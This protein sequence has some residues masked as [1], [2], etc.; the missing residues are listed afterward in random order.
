MIKEQDADNMMTINKTRCIAV[1]LVIVL[2]T[3][4]AGCTKRDS[5][6]E[7]SDGI[8]HKEQVTKAY[9]KYFGLPKVVYPNT[10]YYVVFY[11]YADH[12]PF[13]AGKVKPLAKHTNIGK[14]DLPR[15]AVSKLLQSPP[16]NDPLLTRL[17][18]PATKVIGVTTRKNTCTVDFTRQI[19]QSQ[20]GQWQEQA[21][22]AS[23]THT[24]SQFN[25]IES[26]AITIEGL[27]QGLVDDRQ[28]DQFLGHV[29]LQ[30]QP[31]QPQQDLVL[32]Q[33]QGDAIIL[34]KQFVHE[35]SQGNVYGYLSLATKKDVGTETEFKQNQKSD[36]H[37]V[38]LAD[39][40]AWV[41]PQIINAEFERD[42]ARV[43]LSG[44]RTF[45]GEYREGERS[46]LNLVKEKKRWKV[47]F[48]ETS[49]II[50]AETKEDIIIGPADYNSNKLQQLQ[51]LV[52]QG[53]QPWRL[54]PQQVAETEGKLYGFVPGKDTF[55]MVA[56]VEIGQLSGTGEALFE[57]N[58]ANIIYQ[59]FL[60]QPIK[61]GQSGIW[62]ITMVKKKTI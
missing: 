46:V 39:H 28:I 13:L 2:F 15:L 49:E 16:L 20:S 41:L 58:H 42:K 51:A 4:A 54:D 18:H 40:G 56:K 6:K 45:A 21:M 19:L 8:E 31:F 22:I 43:Q 26:V 53:Q 30:Q 55:N 50:P 23:V 27:D 59:I 11:P 29:A 17:F 14:K 60:M 7:V 3:A 57:V 33:D 10:T 36:L 9:R 38:I 35:A 25:Q 5:G 34:A 1:V 52:D 48:T 44:S 61:A 47:D 62:T 37:K 12:E 24:L 32:T